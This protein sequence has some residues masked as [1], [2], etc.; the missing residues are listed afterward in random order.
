MKILLA[1]DG[2]ACSMR[3]V[4]YVTR[5]V[6]RFGNKPEV[7][8]L[9][10]D[11]PLDVQVSTLIGAQQ[12]ARHHQENGNAALR[13]A[14]RTLT[15][16]RVAYREKMLVGE[17]GGVIARTAAESR[18]HLIVMGSHGRSALQGLMLGSVV[19]KVLA[20]STVPVLVVR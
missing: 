10:L 5:H 11:P 17:P 14:R 6:A 2:S 9:N 8:L 19:T 1:V 13:D 16:A 7:L 3:A 20:Q 12:V 4:R 15:R 18:C